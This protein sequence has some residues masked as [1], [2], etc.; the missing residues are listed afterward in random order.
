M[1]NWLKY[2]EQLSQ[3]CEEKYSLCNQT[4]CIKTFTVNCTSCGKKTYNVRKLQVSTS[5]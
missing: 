5:N 2:Y 1:E 3:I 4:I